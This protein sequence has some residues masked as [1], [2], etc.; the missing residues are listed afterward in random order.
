MFEAASWALAA[1]RMTADA[2]ASRWLEPLPAVEVADR[3]R[4]LPLFRFTSI[5]ELFLVASSGR[6]VRHEPGSVIYEGGPLS[7][8]TSS[9]CSIAPSR[10]PARDRPRS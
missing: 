3:L 1:R 10:G 2:R 8:R 7:R 5:D 9:S 4:R 6:Q